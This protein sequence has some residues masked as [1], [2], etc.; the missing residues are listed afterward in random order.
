LLGCGWD[1]PE[2][3]DADHGGEETLL[4]QN[5]RKVAFIIG[6]FGRLT[7]MKIHRHAERPC[8]PFILVMAAATRPENAPAS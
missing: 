4:P 2:R 3:G 5:V 8:T 7:R 6:H 1:E